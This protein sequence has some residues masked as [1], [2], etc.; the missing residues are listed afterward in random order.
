MPKKPPL[1]PHVTKSQQTSMS[2][3]DADTP[4]SKMEV[5]LWT[6]T[7]IPVSDRE[8]AVRVIKTAL[9]GWRQEGDKI[10]W[11]NKE[12]TDLLPSIAYVMNSVGELTDA[13]AII[14]STEQV[15][16]KYTSAELA[17]IAKSFY[18]AQAGRTSKLF[19]FAP[20][21]IAWKD[22]EQSQRDQAIEGLQTRIEREGL[23][24]YLERKRPQVGDPVT[25]EVISA[26][27]RRGYL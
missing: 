19:A 24:G 16:R 26:L 25:E 11:Y 3:A 22:L 5:R 1:Y 15:E 12:E 17:E 14:V 20:V 18:E 21:Y 4:M 10:V 13:S 23:R 6:G 27:K 9:E 2:G 7:R 8:E